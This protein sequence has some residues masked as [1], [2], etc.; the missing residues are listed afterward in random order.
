MTRHARTTPRR[1]RRR[2]PTDPTCTLTARAAGPL[3][4]GRRRPHPTRRRLPRR[5]RDRRIPRRRQDQQ[6]GRV[7][8]ARGRPAKAARS[9][10]ASSTSRATPPRRQPGQRDVEGQDGPPA[11]DVRGGYARS[12]KIST[13]ARPSRTS[14]RAQLGGGLAGERRDNRG[15]A[16][17]RGVN[18]A[19]GAD[20]GAASGAGFGGGIG[21]REGEGDGEGTVDATNGS[22]V[23]RGVRGVHVA[24]GHNERGGGGECARRRLVVVD[25]TA[26]SDDDDETGAGP[27]FRVWRPRVRVAHR[28]VVRVPRAVLRR[29]FEVVALA[30]AG[31]GGRTTSSR[32]QLAVVSGRPRLGARCRGCS[33][34]RRTRRR[35]TSS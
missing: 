21:W 25:L 28:V 3:P 34:G 11:S 29:W 13:A 27:G 31:G 23:G 26:P 6:R 10:S 8:R 15:V 17:R 20:D 14:A 32:V 5:L 9:A 7:H 12:T 2:S 22:V 24:A 4:R 33:R 16:D 1:R 30:V 19:P 35:T 18:V